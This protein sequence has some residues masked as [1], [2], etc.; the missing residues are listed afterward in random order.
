MIAETLISDI[1]VPLRTSD[2]GEYALELMNEFIVRHLPV[3]NDKELLGVLSE[4]DILNFDPK[5]AVGSYALSLPCPMVKNTDHYYEIIKMMA[6]HNLTCVPVVN[7]ESEYIGMITMEDLVIRFANSLP[8]SEPGAII[9]LEMSK[10]DYSLAELSRIVESENAVVLSAFV[11]THIDSTK[12]DVTLKI[13]RQNALS[14]MA[15][16]ERFGYIIKASYAE[17]EY[18]DILKDRYDSL[19]SYLNV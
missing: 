7:D 11:G 18:F 9:V 14:I 12:I 5:Q 2:T 10:R 1:I 8:F 19:I 15:G 4:D 16:F 13:N 3:V 17:T 6:N